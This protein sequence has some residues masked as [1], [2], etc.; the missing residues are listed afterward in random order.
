LCESHA[1]VIQIAGGLPSRPA[2]ILPTKSSIR[3]RVRRSDSRNSAARSRPMPAM[4]S[5]PVW[6]IPQGLH[7]FFE[8]FDS[9]NQIGVH[10]LAALR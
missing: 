8:V 2:A 7:G 9:S 10:R 5:R 6:E 3:M 1:A 4:S